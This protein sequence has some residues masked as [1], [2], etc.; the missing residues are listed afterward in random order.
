MK[1]L[2]IETYP[3]HGTPFHT[4]S[5]SHN[6]RVLCVGTYE[7]NRDKAV[8]DMIESWANPEGFTHY[9]LDGKRFPIDRLSPIE[10]LEQFT[11]R[12]VSEMK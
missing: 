12:I 7:N 1:T 9:K 8:N 5:G 10:T 2:S 6:R 3:I 11:A 4:V